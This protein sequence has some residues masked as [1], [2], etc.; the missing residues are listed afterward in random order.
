MHQ[1]VRSI[2]DYS[3]PSPR[4]D[5]SHSSYSR[6]WDDIEACLSDL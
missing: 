2:L 5:G 6:D 3:M 4:D 1:D